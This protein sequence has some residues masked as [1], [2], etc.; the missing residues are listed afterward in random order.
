MTEVF[1]TP[2]M[3]VGLRPKVLMPFR[4]FHALG[5]ADVSY[6]IKVCHPSKAQLIK[7]T[8]SN[9]LYVYSIKF[10]Q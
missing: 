4:S 10:S 6:I 1:K 5:G 7:G 9:L 3:A 8:Q 2:I